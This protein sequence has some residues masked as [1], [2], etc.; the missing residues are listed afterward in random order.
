MYGQ[1][2]GGIYHI[3]YGVGC[4]LPFGMEVGRNVLDTFE[5]SGF[6]VGNGFKWLKTYTNLLPLWEWSKQYILLGWQEA[7]GVF[8]LSGVVQLGV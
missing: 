2:R 5:A 4:I 8:F 6:V 3:P 7:R 1:L